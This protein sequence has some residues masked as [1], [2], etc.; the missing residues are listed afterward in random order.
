MLHRMKLRV[1]Y[2]DPLSSDKEA[3][4][5]KARV[6]LFAG[7]GVYLP[8]LAI[9][10]FIFFETRVVYLLVMGL[11]TS[12]VCVPVAWYAYAKGHGKSLSELRK[13]RRQ[14]LNWFAI[15]IG[16]F[17][18]F[19]LFWMVLGIVEFLFGYHAFRAALISFVAIAV[20]RDGFEIGYY[21]A[22]QPNS[23]IA[24][25]PDGRPL[26]D[27]FKARPAELIIL[28]AALGLIG[29]ALGGGWSQYVHS[30]LYQT[31]L[32][33]ITGGALSTVAYVVAVRQIP[34]YSSLVRFFIW[35]ALTMAATYFL[36]FAY[37]LR[38]IFQITF[39]LF[40][41]QVLL[42]GMVSVIM[43][44]YCS[45]LGFLKKESFAPQTVKPV[46]GNPIGIK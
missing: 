37:L 20:A 12:I 39:P 17:Y 2:G 26:M 31:L 13:E 45:F 18:S 7:F 32:V 29:A 8:F 21:R 24:I 25:F 43:V 14:E 3:R 42:T 6:L 33:A 1:V 4:R 11:F 46:P 15:K 16:F 35:P 5:R 40:I 36:I 27:L 28:G 23:K 9:T 19:E 38:I 44:V 22:R 41:D 30:S 34:S 10:Y